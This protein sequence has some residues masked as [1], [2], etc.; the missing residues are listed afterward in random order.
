VSLWAKMRAAEHIYGS[1]QQGLIWGYRFPP[2]QPAEPVTSD[3]A[4]GLLGSPGSCAAGEFVWL[5]F[6]LANTASEAWLRRNLRLPD[7]FF[8]S[9]HGDVGS[10]RLEQTEGALVAVIHDVMFDFKFDPGAV[11]TAC[12]CIETR[13]LVSARR[14]PLRSVDELRTAVRAGQ[15]FRSPA[16]LLAHLLQDQANVLMNILRESTRRID[17]IEDR[18]L[19]NRVS[20]SRADLG[21]LRR[22]LV[23]LQRLLAPEP[24][25]L[26]RLL[27]RPPE[28]I[29]E[30]DVRDLRQSAEEFAAAVGDSRAL[31]ER[32]ELLQQEL[33][34]QV[35][36]QTNRTLFVLTAVTVLALPILLVAGLF[37]MNVDGIPLAEHRHGF[38]IIA[39]LLVAVTALLVYLVFGRRRD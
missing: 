27:N 7:A 39:G 35:N 22:V 6:S 18:L 28:W 30:D 25:A 32:V 33:G 13:F 20:T 15:V 24:A 17:K 19:A 9:L 8:E 34:A 3:A 12:M 1:D 29:G 21:S 36:E 14:S 26:F 16:E 5:H 37:G 38:A 23:R 11:A 31:V 4:A 10:T 2:G